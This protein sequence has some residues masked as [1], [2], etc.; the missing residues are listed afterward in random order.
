MLTRRPDCNHQ[1]PAAT[2]SAA[3]ATAA[4]SATALET[5]HGPAT[6][7]GR[8]AAAR[9]RSLLPRPMS[10]C[11]QATAAPTGPRAFQPA[12][13]GRSLLERED[14]FSAVLPVE[15]VEEGVDGPASTNLDCVVPELSLRRDAEALVDPPATRRE[16]FASAYRHLAGEPGCAIGGLEVVSLCHAAGALRPRDVVHGGGD[17]Q[18][19]IG[20]AP[21]DGAGRRRHRDGRHALVVAGQDVHAPGY[22]AG[23]VLRVRGRGEVHDGGEPV[24]ALQALEALRQRGEH[25]QRVLLVLHE[26]LHLGLARAGL[27]A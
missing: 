16:L 1:A 17:Y 2:A 22:E 6:G 14:A 15:R 26:R 25:A 3:R 10:P 11:P 24:D 8:S 4:P 19:A 20:R 21:D 23:L 12:R 9:L 27:R 13:A 5:R 7:S 18:R